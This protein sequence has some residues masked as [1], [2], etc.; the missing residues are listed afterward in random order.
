MNESDANR[1]WKEWEGSFVRLDER[2][3]QAVSDFA[4]LAPSPDSVDPVLRRFAGLYLDPAEMLKLLESKSVN[5]TKADATASQRTNLAS[6][7]GPGTVWNRVAV[8]LGLTAIEQDILFLALAPEID[9]KYERVFALLQDDVTRR[10]PTIGLALALLISGPLATIEHRSL[11]ESQGRLRRYLLVDF[12]RCDANWL[13]WPLRLG[14]GVFSLLADET[15][16]DSLLGGYQVDQLPGADAVQETLVDH[17]ASLVVGLERLSEPVRLVVF[18]RRGSGKSRQIHAAI[19]ALSR[20]RISLSLG[21]LLT[22]PLDEL[23]RVEGVLERRAALE[24]CV[25]HVVA[26]VFAGASHESGTLLGGSEASNVEQRGGLGTDSSPGERAV[27]KLLL[28]ASCGMPVI[29]ECTATAR[30][31]A[32]CVRWLRAQ[33]AVVVATPD[34]ATRKS[35]WQGALATAELTDRLAPGEIDHLAQTFRFGAGPISRIVQTA[36]ASADFS[37][38]I[39]QGARRFATEALGDLAELI[40]P[41]ASREDLVVTPTEREQLDDLIRRVRHRSTVLTDWGFGDKIGHGKGTNAVFAG[42]SGTGKTMAAEV[43][44][45]ELGIPLFRIDTAAI[46][47]KYIGETEKNIER[48]FVAAEG[49]DAILFFDEADALFGKRTEVQSAHDRYANLETAYLLQRIERHEGLVILATNLLNNIDSA[50]LRRFAQLVHFSAPDVPRRREIWRGIWPSATPLHDQIESNLEIL[51][52]RFNLSGGAIKNVALAAA[53]LAA[54]EPTETESRHPQV[55]LR[56]VEMALR[57]ECRKLGRTTE[58]IEWQTA[59]ASAMTGDA[60]Q[61]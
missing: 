47:S 25:L 19:E 49:C 7:M 48:I 2:L 33:D 39:W 10:R 37:R 1:I 30:E 6:H 45:R 13:S 4:Q 34:V 22:A 32:R 3:H 27:Q 54:D 29:M 55:G 61:P 56:H 43:V 57:Q 44:A 26:D 42:P 28:Q 46:V 5:G 15:G 18:G 14:E 35:A 24:P 17:L 50:F 52:S 20:K 16:L 31:A 9:P 12:E 53:Y 41:R 11:F 36:A 51:A 23:L 60:R 38:S 8:S 21:A 59:S 58:S 40:T